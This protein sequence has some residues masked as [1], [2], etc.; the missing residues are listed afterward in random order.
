MDLM[1]NDEACNVMVKVWLLSMKEFKGIFQELSQLP[2]VYVHGH[3]KQLYIT[4]F[5]KKNEGVKSVVG[6]STSVIESSRGVT[7]YF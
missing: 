2:E 3:N 6:I 4:E 7:H 1:D 5:K